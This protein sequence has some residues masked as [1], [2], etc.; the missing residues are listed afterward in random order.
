MSA[1]KC[2]AFN[3]EVPTQPRMFMCAKHWRMVPKPL[4]DAIWAAYTPGQE[5]RGFPSEEAADKYLAATRD[6]RVYVRE[7]ERSDRLAQP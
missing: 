3:C 2:H 7:L 5:R 1:H 6:A 4:Q